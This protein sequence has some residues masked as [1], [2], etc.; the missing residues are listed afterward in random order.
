MA[1]D[2]SKGVRRTAW[3]KGH[4]IHP[5]LVPFPIA[6]LVGH[7]RG[8]PAHCTCHGADDSVATL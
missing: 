6:F 5:M 8:N 4:P 1:D 2:M 7:D 3:I